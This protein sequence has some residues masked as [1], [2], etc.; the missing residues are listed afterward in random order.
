MNQYFVER[1]MLEKY[2]E[3]LIREEK[4]AETVKKYRH[5]LEKF[6]MFV[7][8]RAV[9]KELAIEYK[10]YLVDNHT[11]NSVNTMLASLN[12]FFKYAGWY[13]CLV[14]TLKIQP[15]LFRAQGREL[16]REEYYRLLEAA[17]QREDEK[18]WLIIQTMCAT[19]IRVGELRYITV[20]A[21]MAGYAYVNFKG[22]IRSIILLPELC[23]LLKDYIARTGLQE[24]SVFVTRN[25]KP[26]DRSNI[27]R[28]MKNLCEEAGVDRNKVFPH[29]L[30]HLFACEYM[31]KC[32]DPIALADLMGHTSLNTTR[33]YARRSIEEQARRMEEMKLVV[34]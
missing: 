17:K 19:G 10:Q 31:E 26:L 7:N 25:G 13:D 33:I 24:G 28:N 5:D 1:E 30:R 18:L 6:C 34:K 21:V 16:T 29:N 11:A 32:E 27:C 22:K 4:S 3:Q 9:T 12:G 8:G 23:A 2:Y 15:E 14:K 20:E